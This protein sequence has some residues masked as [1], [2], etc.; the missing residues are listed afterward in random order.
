LKNENTLKW[1]IKSPTPL[2][3]QEIINTFTEIQA[4]WVTIKLSMM[5]KHTPRNEASPEPCC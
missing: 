3:I 4:E 2:E 5:S 1:H